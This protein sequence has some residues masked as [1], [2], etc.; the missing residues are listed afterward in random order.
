MTVV[1]RESAAAPANQPFIAVGLLST[2]KRNTKANATVSLS[3]R[4]MLRNDHATFARSLGARV[5]LRFLIARNGR[6]NASNPVLREAA[7]EGDIV[8]LNMT[9]AKHRCSLKYFLWF[10]IAGKLFP[11]AEYFVLGDDDVYVQFA[12]LDADLRRVH[13]QT[14]GEKVLWGVRAA[15]SI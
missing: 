7:N 11:S 12:H 14:S 5:A 2:A 1:V 3:R 9:E 6:L 13:A 4:A 8:F 15:F 10:R